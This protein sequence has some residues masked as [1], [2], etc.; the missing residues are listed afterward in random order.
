MK[1]IDMKEITH[2]TLRRV[3][4]VGKAALFCLGLLAMLAL[5][6]VTTVLA[7]VMLA[8]TALPG[9]AVRQRRDL[10]GRRDS[11]NTPELSAPRKAVAS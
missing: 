9:A 11:G 8:A 5:V 4:W 2:W 10:R 7:A 6:V 1:G 3:A